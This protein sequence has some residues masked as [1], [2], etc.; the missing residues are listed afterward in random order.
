MRLARAAQAAGAGLTRAGWS[1][2]LTTGGGSEHRKLFGQ[3]FRAALGTRDAL[4]VGGRNQDFRFFPALPALEFVNRHGAKDT[5]GKGNLKHW[6]WRGRGMIQNV[7][8]AT[9]CEDY[10]S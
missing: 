1:R 3:P 10:R 8:G 4:P 7:W 6:L 2:A 9:V 5:P